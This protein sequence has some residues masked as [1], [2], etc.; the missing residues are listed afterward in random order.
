MVVFGVLFYSMIKVY[1]FNLLMVVGVLIGGGLLIFYI[2]CKVYYL[3]V[4]S[5]DDMGW[6]DVLKVGFV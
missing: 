6:K 1:L 3:C 2:E 4:N 5:I